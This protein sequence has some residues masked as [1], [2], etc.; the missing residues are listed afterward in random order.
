MNRQFGVIVFVLLL[1]FWTGVYAKPKDKENAAMDYAPKRVACDPQMGSLLREAN[2]LSHNETLWLQKRQ[3]V[4]VPAMQEFLY[5][6]TAGFEDFDQDAFLG[7]IF[8][9]TDNVPRVGVAFSGGGYRSMLTGAGILSAMDIRTRNSTDHGL[10]G[11]LQATTYVAGISGGNWLVGSLAW[12]NWTSVQS[13]VDNTHKEDSIW[14]LDDSIIAPGGLNIFKSARRW[15]HIS[16]AIDAKRNAGFETSLT[17]VWGRA[18]SYHFFPDLKRGG[19]DY[20]W[21]SLREN[22]V[23]KEAQMPFPISVA[24]GRYP[25]SRVINLNA[26]IFEFN[27]FEMGSWDATLN[28]FTDVKYLGTNVSDGIP[29][30]KGKCVVNYDNTAFVMGTSSTL[31]NQFLLRI[32]STHLPRFIRK[33]GIHILNGISHDFNDIAVYHPN[34]FK[35]SN[36]VHSDFTVS[37]T[38]SDSLFLVDGGEDDENIPFVPLIRQDRKLDIIFAV[39]S[40]ADMPLQWPDGS[41]LVHTYERQFV[42]QGKGMAFPY[43]PD[44][45]TFV[46]LGLNKRP[47]FFGCDASNLTDLEYVPP[48]I[49]YYPNS[50]HSFNSNQSAFKMSYTEQQRKQMVQNGFEIATRNNFT[51][52]PDFLGCIACAVMRRKQESLGLKLPVECETCFINY[53]WDGTLDTTELPP[54]KQD[55]HHSFIHEQGEN[56]TVEEVGDEIVIN[57]NL[58]QEGSTYL[59]DSNSKRVQKQ[60]TPGINLKIILLLICILTFLV[61]LV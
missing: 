21:S 25:G 40:S 4:T 14:D 18:L 52:D 8:R 43:V 30:D 29:R 61:S 16:D 5:R 19:I 34:P 36:F 31:F 54:E 45:N 38:E 57:T 49:V 46:N 7:E 23:F 22:E 37:I 47:T 27:P 39:D 1:N 32:N 11:L 42:K 28:A 53:C 26:T 24:D 13:V 3:Q 41:S 44:T 15:D 10:G 56:F 12:N 35:N 33:L 48:L 9:D 6:A 51:D 50:E 2:A 59:R 55:L 20:T 60:F 17:D 58:L